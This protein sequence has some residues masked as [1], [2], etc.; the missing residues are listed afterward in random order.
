[1]GDVS[2]FTPNKN[3]RR[4]KPL[5]T[6]GTRGMDPFRGFPQF[7]KSLPL[8]TSKL[9][10]NIEIEI[11]GNNEVYYGSAPKNFNNW[12]EWAIRFC[13][14]QK[15]SSKISWKGFLNGKNYIN[16]LQSSWCH[17]YLSHPFIASWSLLD[18]LAVGC[19]LVVSDVGNVRDIC[20]GHDGIKYVDHRDSS[21][22]GTACSNEILDSAYNGQKIYERNLR[23]YSIENSL[24]RWEAVTGVDLTTTR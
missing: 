4:P 15:I 17:V 2:N 21:Q 24:K 12:Q 5:I 6:Y 19:P 9:G 13:H 23:E 8:I 20:K 3:L 10:D 14:E 18:A 1:M 16:W 7:I 22:I 11:A